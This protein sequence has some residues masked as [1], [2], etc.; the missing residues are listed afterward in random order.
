MTVFI[1]LGDRYEWWGSFGFGRK[2]IPKKSFLMKYFFRTSLVLYTITHVKGP[3][4]RFSNGNSLPR[5][6]QETFRSRPTNPTAARALA[7]R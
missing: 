6:R 2:K 7:P 3:R 5:E 4:D 1:S